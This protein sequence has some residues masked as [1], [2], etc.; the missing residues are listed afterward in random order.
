[1]N[2]IKVGAI[3]EGLFVLEEKQ[4]LSQSLLWQA[5]RHFFER[6]GIE[7]WR[8]R[9]VPHYITNNSYLANTY[10][11]LVFAFLRDCQAVTVAPGEGGFPPLNLSQPLYIIE[12]G[13]GSGRLAFHFLKNFL[14]LFNRSALKE[15]PIK[16]V[17]TDFAEQTLA[18][19]QTHRSLQPFL[20]SGHLDFAHFDAE[21]TQELYLR[22][23]GETISP[24]TLKNPLIL[25]ANYFFDSIP[26]DAFYIEAGQ[27][28][29][30]LVTTISLEAETDFARPDLLQQI[31]VSYERRPTTADYYDEPDLNHI[32]RSYQHRLKDTV[33]LFPHVALRCLRYFRELSSGRLLLI[34]ADKGYSREED[35]QGRGDPHLN[36]HGSFSM[37]VNYHAIGEYFRLHEGQVHLT[38]YRPANLNISAFLLGQQ[39]FIETAQ[40]FYEA[41]EQG[42]PDDFFHLKQGLE[43]HYGELTLPQL[44]AALRLSRWDTN[45]FLGCFPTLLEL[46]ETA[47]QTWRKELHQAIEQ[48]WDHYYP[49]GEEK[50]LAF[51]LGLLLYAL[52][53][54]PEALKFFNLSLHEESPDPRTLYNIAVCYHALNQPKVAL[55]YLRQTVTLDPSLE[56][57]QALRLKLEAERA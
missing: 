15:I 51:N 42:G 57:A 2:Q 13:S 54:Y 16:F 45:L 10:A 32:L 38:G 12:L 23:S 19:W 21:Q 36:L 28:D 30:Y 52:D 27:L 9:I 3:S 14:P 35:L 25:L 34:S 50:D 37:M 18:F 41:C 46:A 53:D 22:Q 1:M 5:Q 20:A 33:L 55:K 7:A 56:S 39:P 47:S 4:R 8:Q 24:A 29:E 31:E 17:L 6:Q 49:L 40:A 44:L 26:Q 43:K 11:R 48:V